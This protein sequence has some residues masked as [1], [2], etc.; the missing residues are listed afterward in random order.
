[1]APMNPNLY[2]N[3]LGAGM[4]P[5]TYGSWGALAAPLAAPLTTPALTPS[6]ASI[7]F[8]PNALMK[9]LSIPSAQPTTK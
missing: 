6:A 8:D 3:W 1:M 5:Q 7:P 9:M 2:M 4:N